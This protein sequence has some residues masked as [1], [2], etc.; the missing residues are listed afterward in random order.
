MASK[1]LLNPLLKLAAISGVEAAVRLH[2][3]R[4]DDV[5]ATDERG[6]TPLMLAASRGHVGIC[7]ILLQA[8]ANLMATDSYGN[9]AIGL[10]LSSAHEDLATLLRGRLGV[11]ATSP[12][13]VHVESTA[14]PFEAELVDASFNLSLWES[15]EPSPEPVADER[16]EK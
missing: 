2:V 16:R 14:P 15:D 12:E 1:Q 10:A 3:R 6:R 11:I 8:G 4:G 5:N 9:D 13:P 7:E